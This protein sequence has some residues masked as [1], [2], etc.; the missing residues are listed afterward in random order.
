[1]TTPSPPLLHIRPQPGDQ[2]INFWWAEPTIGPVT[3]YLLEC[4]AAS[5]SNFYAPSTSN[6]II[7]GLTNGTKYTFTIAASNANGLGPTATY[8][9]VAPGFRPDPPTDVVARPIGPSDAYVQWVAPSYNGDVPVEWYTIQAVSDCNTDPVIQYSAHSYDTQRNIHGLNSNSAYTFQVYAINDPGYSAPGITIS[10]IT[11][12]QVVTSDLLVYL[13]AESYDNSGTWYDRTNNHYNAV[14][15]NGTAAINSNKNGII[16]DGATNWRFPPTGVEGIGSQSNWTVQVWYKQQQDT[17]PGGASIVTEQFDSAYNN[18]VNIAIFSGYGGVSTNTFAGGSF[19]NGWSVGAQYK[20]PAQ[21]EWH[22]LAITCDGSL[23]RTY[24]DG[25]TYGGTRAVGN[26][27]TDY[28]NYYRIGRRW[29]L[30][31]Y[32]IGEI[33]QVLI[34]S[35]AL[36]N[37]EVLQNASTYLSVFT[38]VITRINIQQPLVTDTTLT[39]TWGEAPDGKD[40]NVFFYE[41][42]NSIASGGSLLPNSPYLVTSPTLSL[43]QSLMLTYGKYYYTGVSFVGGTIYTSPAA[44]QFPNQSVKTAIMSNVGIYSNQ[45]ITRWTVDAATDVTVQFYSNSSSNVGGRTPLSTLINVTTPSTT[46]SL[47]YTDFKFNAWYSAVVQAPNTGAITTS[48]VH[49]ST[50]TYT[51]LRVSTI[52]V[53]DTFL[54]SYWTPSFKY[55]T[56]LQYYITDSSTV[57]GGSGTA[58][59]A[60]QYINDSNVSTYTLNIT[61]STG[62][63]YYIGATY[64]TSGSYT[65]TPQTAILVP[66][67]ISAVTLS[68]LT[69]QSQFLYARWT[70]ATPV[71]VSLSYYSTATNVTTGG[72]L[73]STITVSANTSSYTLAVQPYTNA[74]YYATVT[75]TGSPSVTTSNAQQMVNPISTLTLSSLTSYA[76]SLTAIWNTAYNSSIQLNYYSTSTATPSSGGLISTIVTDNGTSSF[77]INYTP[78][79]SVYFYLTA[80]KTGQ[81]YVSTSTAQQMPNPITNVL[82][83]QLTT[84]STDLSCYWSAAPSTAVTVRYYSTN[85]A[86]IPGT[87]NLVGTAQSVLA[88]LSTNSLNP[89][90]APNPSTYYYV[91]VTPASGPE[92]LSGTAVLPVDTA[93]STISKGSIAFQGGYLSLTSNWT[94]PVN[95]DTFTVEAF[96]STTKPLTVNPNENELTFW[97]DSDNY[98]AM[99]AFNIQTTGTDYYLDIRNNQHPAGD[100]P[101]AT[102]SIVNGQWHHIVAQGLYSSYSLYYDGKYLGNRNINVYQGLSNWTT[103]L[104]GNA[105]P[106]TPQN[107]FKGLLT[108]IRIVN[109][110]NIYS[111]ISTSTANFTVPTQP[112]TAVQGSSSNI[113]AITGTNQNQFASGSLK[114]TGGG[115]QKYISPTATVSSFGTQDWTYET[116]INF[117]NNNNQQLIACINGDG[118]SAIYAQLRIQK[119]YLGG[120]NYINVSSRPSSFTGGQDWG[121]NNSFNRGV[122]PALSTNTWYHIAAVRHGSNITFYN[123]G[124]SSFTFYT[125]TIGYVQTP[126]TYT[127]LGAAI[128]TNDFDYEGSMANIR[129]VIGSAVYT[130][131]FTPPSGPLSTITSTQFLLNTLPYN[132]LKDETS[133]Y[134][135]VSSYNATV[136]P[137]FQSPF[138]HIST[139]NNYTALLLNT[140]YDTPFL[141]GSSNAFTMTS[142]G[143]LTISRDNPFGAAIYPLRVPDAPTS[144]QGTAANL[145]ALLTWNIPLANGGA[146]ISSYTVRNLTTPSSFSI[147]GSSISSYT[148]SGLTNG[149]PYS[150]SVYATNSQGNSPSSL[151]T[152]VTPA[153]TAAAPTSLVATHGNQS[154]SIAFT[155]GATNGGTISNYK[156]SLNS[157]AYTAFSPAQTISPV[158]ITGL[159]NGTPYTIALKA[160]TQSGDGI[161]SA[162]TSVTPST[163]PDAPTN[164]Q[165]THGNT[166]VGLTWSA[167]A[168]TGGAAITYYTTK[169][170]TDGTNYTTFGTT[171]SGTSGTVTGL[172]N[173]TAYTF[174]VSATNLDGD[175]ALSAASTAITPSTVP[176]APTAVSATPGINQASVSWTPGAN[177]GSAITSYT[178]KYSTDGT[179]Y[180][181]YGTTFSSSPGTVT[182][183]SPST[184]YTFKVFATNTNGNSSDSSVSS[185]VK[186]TML[187]VISGDALQITEDGLGLNQIFGKQN[188]G[189]ASQLISTNQKVMYTVEITKESGGTNHDGVVVGW[190]MSTMNYGKQDSG[191]GQ[192]GNYPGNDVSSLGAAGDGTVYYNG[193][194]QLSSPSTLTAYGLVGDVIDVAL[195]DGVGWWVRVNGSNWN[196]DSNADPATDT[197]ALSVQGLTNLYP[198]GCPFGF[199]TNG[200]LHLIQQ[201]TLSIPS[202][203]T[204]LY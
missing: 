164:V 71:D 124:V 34:Y 85:S 128:N 115:K 132:V 186:T 153:G 150:F 104:V 141:D 35:R 105:Y 17:M 156:Y 57:P 177:G 199:N 45:L 99:N 172:T 50:P 20:F 32:V 30:A 165:G 175:S 181:S 60:V 82:M 46:I 178:V 120:S 144:L 133:K 92:V 21:Q 65:K 8:R 29:D 168:S 138:P 42:S 200:T 148:Y 125:S 53:G 169:Y 129:L 182:G 179:N 140:N 176:D 121:Y 6:V 158:S 97:G 12:P 25:F 22:N 40:V 201:S 157:G 26:T 193:I 152:I 198:V 202:G 189:I 155:P 66:N 203:Y 81:P 112:L 83:D 137:S 73:I 11:I 197:N 103:F 162:T 5:I 145:Q 135:F 196:N 118:S 14:I 48:S 69:Y 151:S 86:V 116:W 63:Y 78:Y 95:I 88:N 28:N 185:S 87:R 195:H 76:T 110:V 15:E 146:T 154:A 93:A 13:T 47:A 3:S 7:T 163:V 101:V 136:D 191:A 54:T 16:L 62:S 55:P 84:D 27:G 127:T 36:T 31:N 204:F 38:P 183:L 100:L 131:N 139:G 109:G 134:T 37:N 143:S 142:N 130:G 160:V 1:M 188:S 44:L 41:T 74:Y 123:N 171:F 180:T 108:N 64:S 117:P 167:S 113:A 18:T 94:L 187:W 190:G 4:S 61:P 111:G 39:A 91:G 161:A 107:P 80:D 149:T 72:T 59:G 173:G 75:A 122:G 102:S 166:Q 23:Y 89:A 147:A 79:P 96:I 184:D 68:S 9:S 51:N 106:P 90:I 192:F 170:S 52:S 2:Q 119:N 98:N 194:S 67:T 49:V 159:T 24:V 43:T 77:T 114:L 58:F 56:S 70:E 126:T 174:K 10:S 19:S 33:G